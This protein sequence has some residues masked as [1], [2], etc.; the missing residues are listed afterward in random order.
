MTLKFMETLF[1]MI[2]G[3]IIKTVTGRMND[4]ICLKNCFIDV[5]Y[6]LY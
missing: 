3:T 2:N 1:S 6:K 4:N 5:K